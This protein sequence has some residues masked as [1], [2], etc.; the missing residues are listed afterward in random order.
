MKKASKEP[1]ILFQVLREP[2]RQKATDTLKDFVRRY[3]ADLNKEVFI[4]NR[5]YFRIISLARFEIEGR[6]C[7]IHIIVHNDMRIKQGDTLVDELGHRFTAT[8]FEMVHYSPNAYPECMEI[9][10]WFLS[11]NPD[12]IGEYL[13]VSDSLT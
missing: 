10:P 11:G 1:H 9:L 3:R 6:D 8:C 12:E 13:A 5:R 2:Y 4:D 7:S